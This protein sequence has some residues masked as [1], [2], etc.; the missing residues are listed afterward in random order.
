M[1]HSLFIGSALATQN[2]EFSDSS[3]VL[4]EKIP[5]F[6]IE[7]APKIA[8]SES[9]RALPRSC[10]NS[11]CAA[12]R[13]PPPSEYATHAR[14]FQEHESRPLSVVLAHVYHGTVDVAISLLGFAVVINS[15][16]VFHPPSQQSYTFM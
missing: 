14:N 7:T 1:P 3:S 4:P 9:I 2:R 8:L 6:N 16:Y 13:T 15:L 12:F 11:I 10:W 5:G